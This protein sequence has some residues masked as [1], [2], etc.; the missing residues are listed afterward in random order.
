MAQSLGTFDFKKFNIILGVTQL[1]GFADGDAFEVEEADD[2]FKKMSGADGFTDRVKNNANSLN[3]IVRLRQ[4]SPTNQVLS[5]L[6]AADRAAGAPL[7]LL[8]KDRNGTTLISALQAWIPK[9]PKLVRGTNV[10]MNEWR[11]ETGSQ[12]VVNIGGND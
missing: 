8:I 7:P 9:F 3:I 6:H 1:S 10:N 12:Y 5:G 11:I 2:A 4:S